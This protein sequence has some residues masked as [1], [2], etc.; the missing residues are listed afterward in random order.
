[1]KMEGRKFWEIASMLENK[2]ISS[3]IER[4]L[5]FVVIAIAIAIRFYNLDLRPFHHDESVHAHFSYLLLKQ[6]TYKYDPLWHGPFQYYLTAVLYRL[7]GDSEWI[8]RM[9]PAIFGVG[10]VA[11]PFTLKKYLG[12]KASFI[13][14]FLL[15]ISP[16]FLYYSRFFRNDLYLVFFSLA[17]VV[18]VIHYLEGKKPIFIYLASILFAL[19]L[20]TKENAYITA[21]IFSSFVVLYLLYTRGERTQKGIMLILKDNWLPTIVSLSIIAIIY[22][23]FYSFFF[24]N[25]QDSFALFRAV[26]SWASYHT[27]PTAPFFFYA[28]LSLLYELPILIFGIAGIFYF[29]R[30]KD[31]LMVF[32]S[33]WAISS[34]F[35]YSFVVYEKAP[36]LL[37]H[38]LLPLAFVAGK[39]IAN[40]SLEKK[41]FEAVQQSKIG[42]K[43]KTNKALNPKRRKKIGVESNC[44]TA[45]LPKKLIFAAF[46]LIVLSF[47][48]F[49]SVNLNYYHFDDP[50]EPM[51]QAAQPPSSFND[52][53]TKIKE[54]ASEHEGY[55][56]RIQVVDGIAIT[57]YLWYLRHYDRVEWNPKE[58]DAPIILLS[59]DKEERAQNLSGY[60]QLNSSVMQWYWYPVTD[61]LSYDAS[62][63][64]LIFR[65]IDREPV[66]TGTILFYSVK[67]EKV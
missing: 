67:I 30:K 35:I 64:Y 33:Y 60:H 16:S 18:C 57:Q 38:L 40:I 4:Y 2:R 54:V 61:F 42:R 47:C 29:A 43:R 13:T 65:K 15:A 8:S 26:S 45:S 10:L 6:G 9:M 20:C 58:L 17:A 14:A 48:I 41:A 36:W 25:P 56:T 63:D 59:G 66:K 21:F 24:R 28:V 62:R 52:L 12:F 5:P 27:G 3:R 49:T 32:M 31:L 39:F 51:I 1:M 50:A 46:T 23:S 53:M 7:F 37:P 44:E 34:F 22:T 55:Q 19:S 11:L